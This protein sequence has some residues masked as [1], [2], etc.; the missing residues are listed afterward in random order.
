MTSLLK[1]ILHNKSN[2]VR[3]HACFFLFKV[4]ISVSY[5]KTSPTLKSI[6]S[7]TSKRNTLKM[8]MTMF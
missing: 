5:A 1:I 6:L 2:N 3:A 8:L 4:L 7:P